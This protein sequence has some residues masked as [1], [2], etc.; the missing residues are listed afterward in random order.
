MTSFEQH[1][2]M[3]ILLKNTE[4]FQIRKLVFLLE[5][6]KMLIENYVNSKEIVIELYFSRKLLKYFNEKDSCPR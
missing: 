1:S 4:N 2:C 5:K 6:R 3:K